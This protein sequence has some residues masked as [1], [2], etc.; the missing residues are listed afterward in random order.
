DPASLTDN[1]VRRLCEDAQH[2]IWAA[3]VNGGVNVLDRSTG[4]FRH[5]LHS[6]GDP[7]SIR[8]NYVS[9][10]FCDSHQ[11]VWA[12][13]AS[14]LDRYDP[15]TGKFIHYPGDVNNP[16][17][18]VTSM[19]VNSMNEDAQGNIWVGTENDGLIILNPE[20][21]AVVHYRHDD[22]DPTSLSTNSLWSIYMDS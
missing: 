10:V 1:H 20:T 3:T 11:R 14:G 15:G 12:G 9:Y 13:T 5:F 17:S 18:G 8:N 4:R 21:N 19:L 16:D 22:V 7:G 2:R 6:D